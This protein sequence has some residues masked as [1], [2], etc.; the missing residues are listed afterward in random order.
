MP[1]SKLLEALIAFGNVPHGASMSLDSWFARVLPTWNAHTDSVSRALLA[2]V[3]ADRL[4]YAFAGGYCAA[5]QRLLDDPQPRLGALCITEAGGN[6]PRHIDTTLTHEGEHWRLHGEKAFVTLGDRAECLYVA[7]TTGERDG[8]KQISMVRVPANLQGV[9]L[10]PLP[11][12]AFVPEIGHARVRFDN[13]LLPADAVLPDDGYTH[14]VKPFRTIEDIH[15]S[16]A[17]CGLLIGQGLRQ[18][19][20]DDVMLALFSLAHHWLALG[21]ESARAEATHLVLAALQTQ[22]VQLIENVTPH[23]EGDVEFAHLWRRDLP[24][25]KVAEKARQQRTL[26]A[27]QQLM[28]MSRT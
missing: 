18:R 7:A 15:V 21:Q 27:W 16:A 13:V 11:A 6:Q 20:P 5:L 8:R 10:M 28:E 17:C 1:F 4:G 9:S 25:L 26:K 3:S 24:L 14:Y 2:G 19:W 12:M 23:I 22:Q